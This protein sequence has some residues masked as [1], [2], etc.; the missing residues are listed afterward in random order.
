MNKDSAP[1]KD[2]LPLEFCQT[3]WY[4]INKDFTNLV[5]CIFFEMNKITKSM[6]TAIISL[7]PKIT[8]EETSIVKWR[9]ISFLCVDLEI[10][11]KTIT[12]R[13]LP[14]LNEII[15][16]EESAAVPGCHIYDN[17]FAIRDLINSSNK[18]YIPK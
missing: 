18:E 4:L 13:L 17:L 16:L 14:R 2:D 9:P 15:L 11:T 1:G 6:K 3:F 7:I 10:I 8:L 12:K 5:N